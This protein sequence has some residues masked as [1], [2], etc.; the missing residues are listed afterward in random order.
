MI[1]LGIGSNLSSSFGDRYKNI[2]MALSALDH[3][4]V[5]IKK[6]SSYYET[7]SYPNIKNPNF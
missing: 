6:K 3:Y 7:P 5:E 2:E 4:D 1:L